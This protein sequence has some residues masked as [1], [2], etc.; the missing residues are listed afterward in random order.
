MSRTTRSMA[1]WLVA[2]VVAA[3]A[4]TAM[5]QE[6]EGA[7]NPATTTTPADQM[8]QATYLGVGV[9]PLH[10]AL[11]AHLRDVLERNQGILVS[12]VAQDSPAEK[13]G[14]KT[15]DILLTFGDQMLFSP[16]QLVALVHADKGGD[17]VQLG[18]VREGKKQDITV[19][20]G[21][22]SLASAADDGSRIPRRMPGDMLNMPRDMMSRM[23]NGLG[24]AGSDSAWDRFDS[25]T[26]KSLGDGRYHVEITFKATDGKLDKREFEGSRQEIR[27]KILAQKDLPADERDHLLR[28]VDMPGAPL[29]SVLPE[30][31]YTPGGRVIW[32]FRNSDAAF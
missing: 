22:H 13:A 9:E 4:S 31:F 28:A 20:L 5:A 27:G 16:E 24:A 19:T 26:L 10:P 15:N 17:Q 1:L 30:V 7:T 14:L 25:L 21:E 29:Q 6:R 11:W 32:D 2:A 8:Q 18:I 3:V 23:M 12:E